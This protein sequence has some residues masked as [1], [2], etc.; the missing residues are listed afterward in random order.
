MIEKF[1]NKA[2]FT[3]R[4]YTGINSEKQKIIGVKGKFFNP[5]TDIEEEYSFYYAHKNII[6]Q[7]DNIYKTQNN[8]IDFVKEYKI[9]NML[10][11]FTEAEYVE[12]DID[13]DIVPD[14]NDRIFSLY[15]LE[16]IDRNLFKKIHRNL[17]NPHGRLILHLD[18]YYIENFE[19][20]IQIEMYDYSDYFEYFLENN[21]P[22]NEVFLRKKYVFYLERQCFD[23]SLETLKKIESKFK[24]TDFDNS[25]FGYIY[26]MTKQYKKACEY[27][28]KL[29]FDNNKYEQFIYD[30][31][32]FCCEMLNEI[33]NK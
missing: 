23:K 7:I 5:E 28:S 29:D 3:A 2:L 8:D 6:Y 32:K 4:K 15:F 14:N 13:Y 17:L 21:F 24:L 33:D 26:K 20:F 31:Y 10:N 12:L 18:Q 27:Y 30:D 22:P 19:F 9:Y 11:I 25:N 16:N 1:L